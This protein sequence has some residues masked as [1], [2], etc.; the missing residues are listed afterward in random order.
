MLR[1]P[2]ALFPAKR[3]APTRGQCYRPQ[4]EA[5][6]SRVQLSPLLV[7]RGNVQV[8]FDTDPNAARSESALAANPLNPA[9]MVGASKRFTNPSTY[10]FTL[11]AHA[12]FDG[13]Q[14]WQEAPLTLLLTGQRG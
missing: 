4:L 6:E 9:N 12:T 2:T 10:D 1:L 13:G 3:R 8:S 14:S 5:L 7:N 11:T